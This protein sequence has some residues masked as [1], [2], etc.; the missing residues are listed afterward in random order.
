MGI[1]LFDKIAGKLVENETISAEDK[2][3]YEYGLRQAAN[4]F[5]TVATTLVI[6][7]IV[8]MVWQSVLF[9]V[10]YIPLR[11]YAGGYHARTPLRCYIFS[12]ILTIGVLTGIRYIP[13]STILVGSLVAVASTVIFI[14]AP[15]A[16]ENKPLD[17]VET[18]VF[19]K[20]MRIILFAEIALV[21][22]FWVLGLMWITVCIVVSVVVVSGMVTLGVLKRIIL[23]AKK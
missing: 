23:R 11:S 7:F 5:A 6:G 3:L 13:H 14:F 22:L 17:E 1:N 16:D 8:G 10:S 9:M 20:R 19:K 21:G 4:T 15:F 2:E 12:V 18:R